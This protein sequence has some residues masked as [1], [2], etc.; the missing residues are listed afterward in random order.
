[1]ENKY[2]IILKIASGQSETNQNSP[3]AVKKGVRVK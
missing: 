2:K 1:M 3:A